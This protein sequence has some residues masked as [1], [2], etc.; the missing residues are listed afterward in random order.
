MVCCERRHQGKAAAGAHSPRRSS[1]LPR[2][3][4]GQPRHGPAS[5]E[6]HGARRTAVFRTGEVRRAGGNH[7][8]AGC[9][10]GARHGPPRATVKPAVA[11][12]VSLLTSQARALLVPGQDAPDSPPAP[13]SRLRVAAPFRLPVCRCSDHRCPARDGRRA[14]DGTGGQRLAAARRCCRGR[15]R[16]GPAAGRRR[17]RPAA[18]GV[19]P[20]RGRRGT[21]PRCA[22]PRGRPAAVR[23]VPG[24]HGVAGGSSSP[25]AASADQETGAA[26]LPGALAATV[27]TELEAVYGYQVALTRLGG[28][29]GC[30]GVA[31]AGPA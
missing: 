4:G 1:G 22:R 11:R 13:R 29:A 21:G 31:A 2:P 7:A 8:V 17:D 26:T 23:R 5:R 24:R 28:D 19:L 10:R 15:R 6:P 25:A 18:P 3:G 20:R 9:R 12:T 14:G 27:R 30:L 16:H